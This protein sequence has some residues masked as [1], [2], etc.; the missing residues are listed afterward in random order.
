MLA[1][2]PQPGRNGYIGPLYRI[3]NNFSWVTSARALGSELSMERGAS[4][5]RLKRDGLIINVYIKFIAC[6]DLVSV[7]V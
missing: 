1:V 3:E 6:K 7:K 2:T 4:K 5:E